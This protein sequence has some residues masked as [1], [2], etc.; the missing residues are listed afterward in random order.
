MILLY[1]TF[2]TYYLQIKETVFQR[3][4][5]ANNVT[6][7]SANPFM[8]SPILSRAGA[9]A[10]QEHRVRSQPGLAL[11]HRSQTG[12]QRPL[13]SQCMTESRGPPSSCTC[14]AHF[15]C[16]ANGSLGNKVNTATKTEEKEKGKGGRSTKPVKCLTRARSGEALLIKTAL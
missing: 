10:A 1:N 13:P 4:Y 2:T 15:S 7:S 8:A 9:Q 11:T 16:I 6:D 14:P 12:S 5:L 3:R